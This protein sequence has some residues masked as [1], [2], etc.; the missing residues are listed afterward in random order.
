MLVLDFES[1]CLGVPL[2]YLIFPVTCNFVQRA[3]L[4]LGFQEYVLVCIGVA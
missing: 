2:C 4:S 3:L 1:L